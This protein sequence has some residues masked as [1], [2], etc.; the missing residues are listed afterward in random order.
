[1]RPI[2]DLVPLFVR[3]FELCRVCSGEVV[4]VL[5][6]PDTRP[7]Y[8]VAALAA[9]RV[10]GA[11]AFEMS[12]SGMG[13]DAPTEVKGMGM[14]VPALTKPSRL[15]TAVKESLLRCDFI[16]DLIPD[17]VLHIP[18][19]EDL[20]AGGKRI[21]TVVE[22]P[23]LLER[24]FPSPQIKERA[25]ALRRRVVTATRLHLAS[26]A[27]TDLLYELT[28]DTG[29]VQYGF[30]D[31]PGRWDHWPSALVSSYPVDGA[32]NGTVV[33]EQGDVLFPF[34]RYVDTPITCRVEAGYVR[35]I[36][37][38]LEARLMRDFLEAWNDPEVF[39]LSHIG[40]G[41]HPRAQWTS[42]EFY[43]RGELF[44]MD[45]RSYPGG[46]IF[47][48]GPNRYSGRWVEAHLDLCLHNVTAVLDDALVLDA[49]RLVEAACR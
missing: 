28:P 9:A 40:F 36:R 48:T 30:A 13:Q 14:G 24:L 32:A 33:I 44:G 4:A 45:A 31:E 10:L 25:L 15:L 12:V 3:E 46:F 23:D 39:A 8:A 38:G 41:M 17:L 18:V 42:L 47:S 20:L 43:E 19:R 21:L 2:A 35:E 29:T 27:G 16:V 1:M 7:E 11:D 49:G 26:A 5:T 22:A 37:G 6:E 34:K